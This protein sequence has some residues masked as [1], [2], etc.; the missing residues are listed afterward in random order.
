MRFAVYVQFWQYY[1][2]TSLVIFLRA[3]N[4]S[5]LDLKLTLGFAPFYA[6][7]FSSVDRKLDEKILFF[8]RKLLLV[9]RLSQDASIME[10]ERRARVRFYMFKRIHRQNLSSTPGQTVQNFFQI[11]TNEF[12]PCICGIYGAAEN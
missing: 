11:W 4:S 2:A 8:K 3:K 1:N 12:N 10:T 5:F 7:S 6:V 9:H